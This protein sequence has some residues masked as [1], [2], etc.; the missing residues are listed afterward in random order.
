[1]LAVSSGWS[2]TTTSTVRP[3]FASIT[4]R[5]PSA[6]CI[7]V[8]MS[9]AP[10]AL[11]PA[12]RLIGDAGVNVEYAYGGGPETSATASIVIGVDDA[13]RASAAAGV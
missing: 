11:A 13:A 3:S 2:W 10:G 9:N 4:I 6:T 12:L 7:L 8:Q 1:M 5:S